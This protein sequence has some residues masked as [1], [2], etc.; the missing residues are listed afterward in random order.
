MTFS[1]KSGGGPDLCG[2]SEVHLN[3]DINEPEGEKL[4]WQGQQNSELMPL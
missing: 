1:Q 3:R 4:N 2:L